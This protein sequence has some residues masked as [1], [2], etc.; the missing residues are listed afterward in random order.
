MQRID[1]YVTVNSRNQG[2]CEMTEILCIN[3]L[4]RVGLGL[5]LGLGLGIG[6]GLG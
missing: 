2:F 1:G 6:L 5:G 3:C 4:T